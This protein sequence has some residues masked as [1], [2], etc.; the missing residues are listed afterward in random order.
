M[1][2]KA[3]GKKMRRSRAQPERA[4]PVRTTAARK[5]AAQRQVREATDSRFG[6]FWDDLSLAELARRQ[7]VRPWKSA[8]EFLSRFTPDTDANDIPEQLAA[9]RARRRTNARR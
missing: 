4:E 8:R 2:R 5:R 6:G 3:P 9:D 7:G 1:R